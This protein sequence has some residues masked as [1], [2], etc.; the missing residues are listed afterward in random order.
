M[1]WDRSC[2]RTAKRSGAPGRSS[3]RSERIES[4]SNQYGPC[5]SSRAVTH[6]FAS[7]SNA[8]TSDGAVD[9]ADNEGAAPPPDGDEPVHAVTSAPRPMVPP[10]PSARRRLI[11][12]RLRRISSSM[13]EPLHAFLS[14]GLWIWTASAGDRPGAD[15][16]R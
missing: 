5:V 1:H 8:S 15:W 2:A 3:R 9:D 16:T 14:R 7:S 6:V 12:S 4:T 10:S 13:T 11:R